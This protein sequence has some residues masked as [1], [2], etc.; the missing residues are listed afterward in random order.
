[1]AFTPE[2]AQLEGRKAHLCTLIIRRKVGCKVSSKTIHRLGKK[3]GITQPF[4]M[5]IEEAKV[6]RA[7]VWKEYNQL[8]PNS[9]TIRDKWMEK[10]I[11]EYQIEQTLFNH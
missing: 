4:K 3:C 8:K 7:A 11:E 1:M 10:K 5:N 2:A 6:L 9:R